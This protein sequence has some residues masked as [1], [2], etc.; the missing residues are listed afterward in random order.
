MSSAGKHFPPSPH[1]ALDAKVKPVPINN[2]DK[3]VMFRRR[4]RILNWKRYTQPFSAVTETGRSSP[5]EPSC[6]GMVTLPPCGSLT[7]SR[8]LSESWN[9][10][11]WKFMLLLMT[12]KKFKNAA[13]TSPK[14]MII[15]TVV[16]VSSHHRLYPRTMEF[17]A[18]NSQNHNSL[19]P[20]HRGLKEPLLRTLRRINF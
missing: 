1:P 7:K 3:D 5:V 11:S 15:L 17:M 13:A 20:A 6:G 16:F 8:A 4:K 19:L 14:Q 10:G 18:Q 2:N 9:F 12:D